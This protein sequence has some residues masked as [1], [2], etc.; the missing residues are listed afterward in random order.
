MDG[1]NVENTNALSSVRFS[2]VGT[3]QGQCNFVRL[4]QEPSIGSITAI[5]KSGTDTVWKNRKK[6][7]NNEQNETEIRSYSTRD[8]T[9]PSTNTNTSPCVAVFNK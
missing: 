3:L 2:R 1:M 5:T 9:T 7:D 8:G 6:F 4:I